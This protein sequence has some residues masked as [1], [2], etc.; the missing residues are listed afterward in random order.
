MGLFNL[1]LQQVRAAFGVEGSETKPVDRAAL[2]A[3]LVEAIEKAVADDELTDD[4]IARLEELRNSLG[5]TPEELRTIQYTALRSLVQKILADNHVSEDEYQLI[6]NLYRALGA[7]ASELDD[8]GK[9]MVYIEVLYRNMLKN[10][11]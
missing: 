10:G 8:V 9:D 2:Q 11:A 5:L 3:R 6:Q 7:Q 4:E 1:V